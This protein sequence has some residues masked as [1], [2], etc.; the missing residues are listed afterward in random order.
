V[1]NKINEKLGL[2]PAGKRAMMK[3]PDD[4]ELRVR[5]TSAQCPACQQRG[6]RLAKSRGHEGQFFCSWCL[7]F[8]TP[9]P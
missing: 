7:H 4:S 1:S 9:N 2:G 5:L 8:W 3:L 6:A